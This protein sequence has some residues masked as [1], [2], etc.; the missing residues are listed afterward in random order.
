MGKLY[1]V[2]RSMEYGPES[3]PADRGQLIEL[4]GM[5]NDEALVR[6]GY[7]SLANERAT[8]VSCGKCGAKFQTDEALSAHG[9]YRHSNRTLTPQQEDARED[10]RA[11]TEDEVNPIYLD[12]TKAS[13]EAGVTSEVTTKVSK[14]AGRRKRAANRVTA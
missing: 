2:R 4:Q 10:A 8:V 14:Q 3:K 7:V 5:K 9:G 13:R 11:K 1:V 12:Q 6:L